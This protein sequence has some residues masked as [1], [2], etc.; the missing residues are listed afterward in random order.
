M[1]VHET[2][3]SVVKNKSDFFRPSRDSYKL[4]EWFEFLKTRFS[5]LDDEFFYSLWNEKKGLRLANLYINSPKTLI[6]SQKG[7]TSSKKLTINAIYFLCVF[8]LI[9]FP[10]RL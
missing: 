5:S 4:F 6:Y 9:I 10:N 8:K 1:V 7:N 3:L 2:E